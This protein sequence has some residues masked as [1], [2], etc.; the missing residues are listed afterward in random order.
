M[1]TGLDSVGTSNSSTVEDSVQVIVS[2]TT[3]IESAA[4]VESDSNEAVIQA[5]LDQVALEKEAFEEAVLEKEA[6]RQAAVE[7]AAIEQEALEK[8]T[9][10][11]DILSTDIRGVYDGQAL[12]NLCS[13]KNIKWKPSIVFECPALE[14]GYGNVRNAALTCLRLAIEAGGSLVMPKISHRNPK[15]IGDFRTKN[16]MPFSYLFDTAHFKS[17]LATYCPQLVIHDSLEDLKKHP[18]ISKNALTLTPFQLPNITRDGPLINNPSKV[19]KSFHAWLKTA[20]TG[21]HS[22]IRVSLTPRIIWTWPTAHDPASLVRS[23]SSVIRL[24]RE[25]RLPAA[26]ALY[27][28]ASEHMPPSPLPGSRTDFTLPFIGI[29]LRAEKD[30]KQYRL[31][32]YTLQTNYY[33]S[34]LQNDLLPSLTSSSSSGENATIPIYIASGDPAQIARFARQLSFV[35]PAIEVVTKAD[36]LPNSTLSALSWDQQAL[37]DYQVMERAAYVMGVRESSFAWTLALKRAAAANWVVGGFPAGPCWVADDDEDEEVG[38]GEGR[39]AEDGV[40]KRGEDEGKGLVLEQGER[41][42]GTQEV[43]EGLGRTQDKAQRKGRRRG[44]KE[45]LAPYEYWRDELSALVGD[46]GEAANE[47]VDVVRSSIWP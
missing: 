2:S 46:L 43:D 3:E 26:E 37:I 14:G 30:A 10:I 12:Y 17:T 41:R 35:S 1:E 33:L 23:F 18:G 25:V 40:G 32:N 38:E 21:H 19:R 5:A 27:T 47:S 24:S 20:N 7:K 11:K 15:D 4:V 8:E 42:N 45:D 29:H 16:M 28:L 36:L 34:R 9:F 39:K 13:S 22:P 31:T 6:F 44:C